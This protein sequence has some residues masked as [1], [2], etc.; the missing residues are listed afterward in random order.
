M[1]TRYGHQLAIIAGVVNDARHVS[2]EPSRRNGCRCRGIGV[3][4]YIRRRG[5]TATTSALEPRNQK[6]STRVNQERVC[7]NEYRQ[8]SR[9]RSR[10]DVIMVGAD[11]FS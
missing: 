10:E 9:L 1:L 4:C 5:C 3:T 2:G 8:L 11:A 6:W 7:R